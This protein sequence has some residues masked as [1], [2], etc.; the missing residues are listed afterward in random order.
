MHSTSFHLSI[1]FLFR[2]LTTRT[3]RSTLPLHDRTNITAMLQSQQDLLRQI[4]DQQK[5][6]ELKHEDFEKQL[7]SL[8]TKV[9]AQSAPS[10]SSADSGKRKRVVSRALSVSTVR[11]FQH[12]CYL[13][14]M[15]FFQNKVTL[16][17]SACENKFNPDERSVLCLLKV[18][19]LSSCA[20]LVLR[21][22]LLLS[23]IS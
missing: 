10:S 23:S 7:K 11:V 22:T 13:K 1:I 6:F 19:S 15:F 17:H 4:L 16:V 21:I 8:E 14:L 5:S 2:L 9:E 3:P 20:A 12:L 18:Y